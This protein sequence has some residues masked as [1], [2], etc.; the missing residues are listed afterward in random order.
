MH[1]PTQRKLNR[2]SFIRLGGGAL[3]LATLPRC[4]RLD[5]ES[6]D[7]VSIFHTTDLHGN[8][9]PTSSYDGVADLG[10]LARCAG[11]L[12]EWRRLY[13]HSLTIDVGDLYQGTD[14]SLRSD[15]R[16]MI[17]C[18]NHLNFDAWVLGNHELDWGIET[19]HD[20]VAASD[21]PVLGGNLSLHDSR[22]WIEAE[23]ERSTLFP[24]IMREVNGYRIAVVG[25]TTPNMANWFLP[26]LT[27]GF[28]AFDP[29]PV[30]ESVMR[31]VEAQRPDAIILAVHMGVRPWSREDDAANRLFAITEAFPQID[32]IIAGH[33]HRD[34]PERKVNSVVYTQANYFGIH[35]GHLELH[36]DRQTRE[37]AAI[38]PATELM[39]SRYGLDPEVI[40]LTRDAIDASEAHLATPVGILADT[41]EFAS[42]PAQPSPYE[43]LIGS[44]LLDGLRKR[45]IAVD[46]AIH[47]LLFTDA[48]LEAGEKTVADMWQVIPFENF[49]VT[50]EV[51][52]AQLKAMMTEMFRNRNHR[53][54]M[55]LIPTIEGSGESL[56]VSAI[57][58]PDGTLLETNE[59]VTIVINSYD[60]ASGGA[61]FP[62]TREILSEGAA[63]RILHRLQS[64]ALLIEYFQNN[65]P[66]TIDG[67]V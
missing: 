44:A 59:R 33:T 13:P 61:R 56:T 35:L 21:M 55:G 65:S 31:E 45:G 36:F 49:V 60:A 39:D 10:G 16:I 17:D 42:R 37:L 51:T 28:A 8:I 50:A 32:A 23:R 46:A 20:A 18:L 40:A 67:L 29:V 34:Q 47:G 41:L 66:V 27:P 54:L 4:M 1:L 6:I 58:R 3:L 57:Q 24:Y 7:R 9:L 12:K 2:R 52:I 22:V 62:L 53:S 11:R 25:L 43:R 63:N 5:A 19:V 14:V 15:G 26:D 38:R 48:P 64:R 30:M